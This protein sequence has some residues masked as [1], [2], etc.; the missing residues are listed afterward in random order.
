MLHSLPFRIVLT[1]ALALN[2]AAYPT[3]LVAQEAPADIPPPT[4]RSN[5]RLVIVDV[6]ITDK[7]GQPVS[8]LKAE[9][10]TVEEN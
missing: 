9:D 5:T 10:F 6:V 2:L 7:K 8:G 3:V 4:I 1:S